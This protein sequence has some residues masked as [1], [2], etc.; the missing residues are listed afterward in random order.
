MRGLFALLILLNAGFFIWQYS[1]QESSEARPPTALALPPDSSIKPLVLLREAGPLIPKN[2]TAAE[3]PAP[4]PAI[5]ATPCYTIGPFITAAEAQRAGAMLETEGLA[6][7]LRAGGTLDNPEH[8]LDI[9]NNTVP[10]TPVPEILWQTLLSLFAEIRQQPH[11][12]PSS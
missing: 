7:S 8:W 3:N 6:S 1:M 11:T 9:G 10:P 5:A 4:P 12:C 2:T